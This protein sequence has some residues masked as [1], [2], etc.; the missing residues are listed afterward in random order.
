MSCVVCVLE[1][2]ARS[3]LVR[4]GIYK[5]VNV[6]VCVF[7]CVYV[8]VCVIGLRCPTVISGSS[9]FVWTISINC[10][11]WGTL[12]ESSSTGISLPAIQPR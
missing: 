5:K 10:Y 3:S 6:C 4:E 11:S 8:C 2:G 7:V 1:P 9:G 12:W